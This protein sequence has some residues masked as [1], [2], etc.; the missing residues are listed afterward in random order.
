MKN[1]IIVNKEVNKTFILGKIGEIHGKI[2]Q[3]KSELQEAKN[4]YSRVK[5]ELE[6]TP[7]WRIFKRYSLQKEHN[8]LK[9]ELNLANSNAIMGILEIIGMIAGLIFFCFM[10]TM[11][12]IQKI[13]QWVVAGFEKRDKKMTI[14]AKAVTSKLKK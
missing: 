13:G 2:V 7:Q 1:D 6:N 8:R 10:I 9:E 4:N 12:L 3:K 11:S 5:Y 14:L